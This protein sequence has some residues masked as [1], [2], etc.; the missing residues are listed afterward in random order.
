MNE[1][2]DDRRYF[3][4]SDH[5]TFKKWFEGTRQQTFGARFTA[6]NA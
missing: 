6:M 2:D 3:S 4:F 5:S 1:D